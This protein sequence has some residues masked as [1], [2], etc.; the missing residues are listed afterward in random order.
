MDPLHDP[1]DED[2]LEPRQARMLAGLVEN[3]RMSSAAIR[4]GMRTRVGAASLVLN[5]DNPLPTANHACALWGTLAEVASTLLLLEDVFAEAGRPEA[6]VYAS[7][8]TVA[9]I[10]GIAD[11]AGWRAVDESL[12]LLHRSEQVSY[13]STRPAVD[14]DLPGIAELVADDAG[15]ST[16]AETRLVRNL[17]HR[18]DDARCVLH[19]VDD[20]DAGADRVAGFVQGFTERGVG[21]VEQ[22]I[23]RPGRR[24]R[25]IGRGLVCAAVSELRE[26]GARLVAAHGDESRPSERF[27]ESCGFEPA[28]GVTAYARRVDELLG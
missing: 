8:T 25:G 21:L 17:G 28:Y 9:E 27:A 22:V 14:A 23:V 18:V 13:V 26:R 7:P 6:L 12:A 1:D 16:T 11:D 10:E 3:A 19:V 15:L 2:L 20:P 5:Q 4:Y 24:R